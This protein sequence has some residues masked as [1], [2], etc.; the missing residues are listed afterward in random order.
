V[1]TSLTLGNAW[2]KPAKCTKADVDQVA[3][4]IRNC[5]EYAP[6]RTRALVGRAN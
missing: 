3:V 5:Y 6:L 4:T 2:L 1:G